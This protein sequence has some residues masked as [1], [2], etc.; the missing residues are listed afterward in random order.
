MSIVYWEPR[1]FDSTLSHSYRKVRE[2]AVGVGHGGWKIHD[3]SWNGRENLLEIFE[4]KLV[5]KKVSQRPKKKKHT[6]KKKK[7]NKLK[8]EVRIPTTH[9]SPSPYNKYTVSNFRQ[10]SLLNCFS[11]I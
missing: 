2:T 10:V 8:V 5:W 7:Q 9:F 11:E 4:K 6:H 1:Y 3:V